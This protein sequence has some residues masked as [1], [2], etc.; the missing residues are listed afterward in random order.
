MP[1]ALIAL[2]SAASAADDSNGTKSK[3]K[4]ISKPGPKG[5]KCVGCSLFVSP[6]AC[7]VV[8]GKISPKGYCIAFGLK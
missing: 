7:T 1:I 2:E 6:A 3:F 5:Q 4:Y 8:K